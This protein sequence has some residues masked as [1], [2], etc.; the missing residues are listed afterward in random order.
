[1]TTVCR[2]CH[3][4]GLVDSHYRRLD[5]AVA[6]YNNL[7]Y[8]PALRMFK[9]KGGSDLQRGKDEQG[10]LD[11]WCRQGRLARHGVAMMAPAFSWQRGFYECKKAFE[12]SR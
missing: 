7:Y 4:E 6:E 5:L 2:Q 8:G 1:M 10:L 3:G 9:D 12:K 11:L